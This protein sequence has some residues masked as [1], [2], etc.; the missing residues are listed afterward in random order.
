MTTMRTRNPRGQG[1]QLKV[2]LLNAAAELLGRYGSIDQVSLRSVANHVGVTPTSVYSHFNDHQDLI[3]QAVK[4]CWTEFATAINIDPAIEPD[5]FRRFQQMGQHYIQ[6]ASNESGKY[7]VIFANS[8]AANRAANAARSAF[9]ILLDLVT[10]ILE[11]NNDQR[12]PI[13]VA[14]QAHTWIHGIVDLYITNTNHRHSPNITELLT[15]IAPALQL[16]PTTPK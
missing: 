5:P 12:H 7:K 14:T 13:L 1:E 9:D 11:A 6:F 3:D 2:D 16:T 4:Y 10:E 8:A 15:H